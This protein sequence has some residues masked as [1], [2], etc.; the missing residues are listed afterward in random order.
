MSQKAGVFEVIR[1]YWNTPPVDV[2]AIIID[3]G[4]DYTQ[5]PLHSEISG[6]LERLPNEKYK[7]SVN[8]ADPKVRQRFTAAHELG[9]YIYHRELVGEGVDDNLV[10]RSVNIGKYNNTRITQKQETEA[11]RFAANLLMPSHLI[12]F[13]ESKGIT[14]LKHLAAALGVSLPAMRIRKGLPPYPDAGDM[15]KFQSLCGG[16]E[17][18]SARGHHR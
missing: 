6:M 16:A 18:R 12:D 2:E 3:T 4:I 10:Y 5:E 17:S 15:S 14:D 8:S 9:H 7:I 11:N 1:R 13:L